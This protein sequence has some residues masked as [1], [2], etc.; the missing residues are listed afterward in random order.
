[1]GK[2]ATTAHWILGFGIYLVLGRWNLM[3]PHGFF[4]TLLYTPDDAD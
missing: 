4:Q 1:M 2:E 3:L